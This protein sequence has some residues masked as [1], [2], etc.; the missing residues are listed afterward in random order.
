MQEREP[1]L[2]LLSSSRVGG[3]SYLAS[4][5][6][7]ICEHLAGC[8][9][10]LFV[11][12]AGVTLSAEA[13]CRR[14]KDALPLLAE[15]IVVVHP[16]DDAETLL[17]ECDGVIVGGGNTFVLLDQ[18]YRHGLITAIRQRVARGMPYVGWSAGSNI[19][20][21]T[22]RTTNDMPVIEPPSF[23][24][25]GFVSY[26]INPH[27][28]DVTPP[29][30]HGETRRDRLAEFLVMNP[31]Q[32]V[33]ALPEGTGL[34]IAHGQTTVIGAYDALLFGQQ[35]AIDALPVG[36]Q[37]ANGGHPADSLKA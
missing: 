9:R 17:A 22:I 28:T 1:S 4:A 2:L 7:L 15:R 8:T 31:Q 26:Q 16:G 14:V 35:G 21:P 12:F 27:F 3:G 11:P 36:A 33:V 29:N 32:V 10:I 24:S 34:K 19:A 13:Y 30:F 20:G 6:S 37:W 23:A 5:A 25:F 18:L